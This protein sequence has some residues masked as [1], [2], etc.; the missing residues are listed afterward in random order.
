MYL[1]ITTILI[2][3]TFSFASL[4]QVGGNSVYDFINLPNSARVSSLG[5]NN[6]SLNDHDLNLPFYNPSLL[7]DSMHHQVVMNFSNYFAGINYGYASFAHKY[8]DY[9]VFAAGIQYVN[10]GSFRE[11]DETGQELGNFKSS[12]YNFNLMWAKPVLDSMF[13]VGANLKTV[14]SEMYQFYSSAL[15]LDAGLTYHLQ[16]WQMN[17]ALVIKNAGFQLKPYHDSNREPMPFD[18][19]MGL[20]KKLK[21]APIRFSFTFHNLLKPDLTYELQTADTSSKKSK[22]LVVSDKVLRHVIIGVELLPVKNF[23]LNIGYNHQRRMELQIETRP[24]LSGI[25]WGFGFKISKFRFSY[26]RARYHLAGATNNF[27]VG[28]NI[29]DFYKRVALN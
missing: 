13:T 9:G 25:S 26:G 4:A 27:S 5:G 18:I 7:T 22:F 10:Y 12:E 2:L 24:Y 3:L 1:K 6:I 8:N 19:Q 16:K 21:H 23:F 28:M 29:D 20:T 17:A 15:L 11:T 14:Y